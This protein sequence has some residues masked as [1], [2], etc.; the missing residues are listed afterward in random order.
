MS[1]PLYTSAAS[2]WA[3]LVEFKWGEA[4]VSRYTTWD[5][6]LTGYTADTDDGGQDW[7]SEPALEV[8]PAD[9]DGSVTD[10]PWLVRMPPKR[11]LDGAALLPGAHLVRPYKH[12][13]VY[14]RI[15]ETDPTVSDGSRAVLL[16]RGFVTVARSNPT[17][18]SGLVELEVSGW[19][20]L[21]QYPLGFEVKAQ[22]VNVFGE[23][24]CCYPVAAVRQ[25][26]EINSVGDG[27]MSIVAPTVTTPVGRTTYWQMGTV[28]V[29]GLSIDI[30]ADAGSGTF[31]LLSP[32]PPEWA[33]ATGTFT[34][35]CV[36]T[37][38]ACREWGNE[39]RFNGL[40]IQSPTR[41]PEYEAS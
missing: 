25:V 34:P 15:W 7:Q 2:K 3:A 41:Q 8:Q 35:G 5:E 33:G 38:T 6:D 1:N 4:N 30:L 31:K 20:A 24:P 23:S 26:A 9:N 32:A 19:R 21:I 37:L 22:C 40:G 27:G 13:R 39:Q 12:A 10:K 17:G 11:A 28:T 29:D 14:A 36:Q 18:H 16:W